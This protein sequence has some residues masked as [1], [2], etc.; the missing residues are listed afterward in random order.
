MQE[1]K[2][3]NIEDLLEVVGSQ[4]HPGDT[5]HRYGLRRELL[6]SRYFAGACER[7]Q[8]WNRIFSFT[9]PLIVGGLLVGVFVMVGNSIVDPALVPQNAPIAVV[10]PEVQANILFAVD[11]PLEPFSEFV[12]IG[13]FVPVEQMVRFVPIQNANHTLVR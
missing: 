1:R 4:E 11:L 7:E 6:C 5:K 13:N 2:H 12:D 3:V 9:A 8:Q 10:E